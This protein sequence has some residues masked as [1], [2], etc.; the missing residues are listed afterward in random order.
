MQPPRLSELVEEHRSAVHT[1]VSMRLDRRLRQK[2]AVSDI[3]QSALREV[4]ANPGQFEYQGPEAF[5]AFLYR[6]VEHKIANKRRYWEREKR[7]ARDD[8]ALDSS[9]ADPT[10]PTPSEV[11]AQRE[12]LERLDRALGNLDEDDRKLLVMKRFAGLPTESIARETGLSEATV[13]RRVGQVMAKLSQELGPGS[14]DGDAATL[15]RT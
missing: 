14:G 12:T 1:Y 2:E 9:A 10:S 6:A 7:A 4:L 15:P 11:V 3:V 13:R 8:E 5:R